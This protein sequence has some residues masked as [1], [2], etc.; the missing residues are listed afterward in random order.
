MGSE[1]FSDEAARE[2]LKLQDR[3]RVLSDVTRRFAEATTDYSRLLDSVAH[4]LGEVIGDSCVVFLLDDGGESLSAVALHAADPQALQQFR[5]SFAT[6]RLQ[7]SDQPALRQILATGEALLVPRLATRTESSPEQARWEK[8]LGLHSVLVVPLRVQGRSLGALTLGRFRAESPPF[9]AADLEL[10][11]NLADHA[12]LAI[13]NARLY[14]V[15][16]EARRSAEQAQT[17]TQRAQEARRQFV[18]NSP[19]AR[20]IVDATTLD[21]LDGNAAALALYGYARDEFLKLNLVELRHPQDAERLSGMMTAAGDDHTSGVARHRR[22]DG[23]TI[24]VEGG[25]Q[26]ST[27]KGRPARFVVVNDQTKR[28]EA[29]LAR[30]ESEK[31]LHRTLDDMN[32]GYTIMGRDLRYL[33]MNRAGAEQTHLPRAQLIGK[34]PMELYPGFE[35]TPIHL[36][37]KRAVEEGVRQRIEEEFLHADGE[38]GCFELNIQPV[39]EGLVV[40]SSDQTERRRVEK[41]RDSLEG[42]LRQAQKLE[43]IGRLAGGVAHDFNNLLSIILGYGE[44]MLSELPPESPLRDDLEQIQSAANRAA[45]LTRQLLMFS[46]QQVLEPKVMSLNDVLDG[47]ERMLSRVLGEQLELKFV[48]S[49]ELGRVRADRG[50]IEQVII[51]LA[52]NA[53]DA[54][55]SGGRLTIETANVS[56]DEEFVLQHLG[57]TPGEYVFL[58]VTD[59]GTGMDE[60]TRAQIFEPFF[61]T[62]EHGKGTGLGLSTVLGIVQQSGGGVWVYSEPGH[63]TTFKIYLPRVDAELDAQ[64]APPLAAEL[65]G[66]ETILLVE[67][68][69]A[70]R[71]VAR[72]ILEKNGYQV[73]VALSPADAILLSQRHTEP[74]H[75][76]LT[77]VIMPRMTGAELSARLLSQRPALKVLYMSGYTDG[78][79]ASQGVLESGASFVQKPFTSELLTRK[80]RGAL[81]GTTG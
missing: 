23:S 64:P 30:D 1:S 54:M 62:K 76:V 3:L 57:S 22:K 18:E 61:S 63:G 8:Q 74:I 35:G 60:A 45:E 50:S 48:R 81:N 78:S 15:A 53:R 66:S 37:L 27:F 75:L 14:E 36:A 38:I 65:R 71:E 49:P 51:N 55:P 47:L 29:E 67:D 43:A 56:V 10:A 25:S 20:Y 39:P 9:D 58:G 52:V 73:L 70:V 13:E 33:Y 59:T 40:L 77:D 79:I 4:E 34:T 72:R 12:A 11:K 46:R 42:Q 17:A 2:L 80:V 16:A 31:R 26:V 68:E 44:D 19:I 7:L 41:R 24:Y 28:V 21:L 69:Q 6:R 32:E 5:D